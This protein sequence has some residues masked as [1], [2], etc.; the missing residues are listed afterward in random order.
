MGPRNSIVSLFNSYLIGN[1][2]D[3]FLGDVHRVFRL[4]GAWRHDRIIIEL[5][6][7]FYVVSA[8][9]PTPAPGTGWD[10]RGI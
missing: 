2:E 1:F 8:Y 4:T 7:P 10:T 6:S 5:T 3:H 9:V